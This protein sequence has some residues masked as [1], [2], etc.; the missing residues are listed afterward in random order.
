V[1]LVAALPLVALLSVNP[2]GAQGWDSRPLRSPTPI[3][4]DGFPLTQTAFHGWLH[5]NASRLTSTEAPR[6]RER[7]YAYISAMAKQRGGRFP[8]PADSAAFELF[9]AAASVG[10]VGAD[11]V[12]RE[13]HQNPVKLPVPAAI[14]GFDLRLEPPLFSL[15]SDDGS[16]GICYPYYFMAA[17]AGRQ[18][19]RNGVLT[20]VVI[21]S[22]LFAPDSGP[23]ESSQATLLLVAAPV[24]DSA[25]H[26]ETWI[27]QLGVRSAPAPREVGSGAWYASPPGEPMHRLAVVR[28]L[29]KRVL[30]IGYLGYGGTFETNR[31]HFF[32]LL[33][34]LAPGRCRAHGP[35]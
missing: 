18:K 35:G 22:T 2:A 23:A 13:L 30:V 19:P 25:K 33:S 3:P 29:P 5:R 34:T 12:A 14:P 4:R 27:T 26:V 32:N 31:P 21:L 7:L 28:R 11:R 24:A 1:R 8:A 15:S 9:R 17:P 16:W 10:A 20:E 6:V